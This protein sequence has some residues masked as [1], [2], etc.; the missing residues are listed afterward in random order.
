MLEIAV[1]QGQITRLPVRYGFGV[2]HVAEAAERGFAIDGV[3]ESSS[4]LSGRL[5]FLA[6]RCRLISISRKVPPGRGFER[7][8]LVSSVI[9]VR[10]YKI[11]LSRWRDIA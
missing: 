10:C 6:H 3:M 5:G 9:V 7:Y 2:A 1:R 11:G 4:T 8:R